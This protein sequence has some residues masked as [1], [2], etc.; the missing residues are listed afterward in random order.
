[1]STEQERLVRL[2]AAIIRKRFEGH[3]HTVQAIVRNMPD[4]ELVAR[5]DAAHAQGVEHRA[6]KHQVAQQRTSHGRKR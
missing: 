4:E 3:S 6:A 1:M 5:E 2:R